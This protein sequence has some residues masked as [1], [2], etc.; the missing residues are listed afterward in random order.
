M[1]GEN[2]QERLLTPEYLAGFIDGEGCFSISIHPNPNAK[3]G[4]LIDPDFT[5]NQHHQSLELL[6]SIQKF[7]GCGKIYEKSPN[8]SNVLTFTVYGRRTIF[9]KIIPFLDTHPI[10]SN[11]RHDYSK[12]RDII[13]RMTNKEHHTLEGFQNIVRIAFSMNAQGRQRKYKLE[14]VLAS[15]SETARRASCSQDEMKIQSELSSDAESC[16]EMKQPTLLETE[17]A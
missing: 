16:S 10:I 13:L 5:I 15:S 7:F 11:K 2:Q 8:K 9:E 17:G 14:E 1:N 4:W 6:E 3:W 12:F